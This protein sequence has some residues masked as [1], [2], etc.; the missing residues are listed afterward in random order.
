MKSHFYMHLTADVCRISG[1]AAKYSM[2]VY[3]FIPCF[4]F[5]QPFLF[6]CLALF[7]IDAN[8]AGPAADA[9]CCRLLQ[10]ALKVGKL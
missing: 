2:W 1:S 9:V 8:R 6:F 3:R 10:V 4:W 7:F 5:S